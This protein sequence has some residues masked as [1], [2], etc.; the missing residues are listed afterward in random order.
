MYNPNYHGKWIVTVVLLHIKQ[1]MVHFHT[2]KVSC[3]A[4]KN[5]QNLSDLDLL[6]IFDEDISK[7]TELYPKEIQSY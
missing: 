1:T 3:F 6:L 2:A 7:N 5:A 4:I